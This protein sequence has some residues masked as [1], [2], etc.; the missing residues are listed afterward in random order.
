MPF[1]P[2]VRLAQHPFFRDHE[3]IF[4]TRPL[5]RGFSMVKLPLM[6]GMGGVFNEQ[7]PGGGKTTLLYYCT[8]AFRKQYPELPVIEV[9][10]HRLPPAATRSFP[11]RLA[12]AA[13]EPTPPRSGLELRTRLEEIVIE[14]GK[15]SPYKRVV[16]EID[17]AQAMREVEFQV[18][19]DLHNEMAASGIGL[20]VLLLGEAGKL[21]AML[22]KLRADDGTG[23]IRRFSSIEVSSVNYR[24]VADVASACK[25]VDTE[26]WPELDDHT[27]VESLF[28]NGAAENEKF[29]DFAQWIYEDLGTKEALAGQVFGA[30]RWLLIAKASDTAFKI[31]REDVTGAVNLARGSM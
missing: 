2:A 29:E 1:D 17:E 8:Q 11:H 6:T 31:T 22:A 15:A 3:L 10:S 24:D 16:V 12:R 7:P 5:A 28:P 23:L 13:G 4:E 20:S 27:V 19:K 14:L 30:M 9:A 21:R 25:A 26:R 18:L